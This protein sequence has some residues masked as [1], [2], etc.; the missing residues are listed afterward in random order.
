MKGCEE[1]L[2][3]L[4]C[5]APRGLLFPHAPSPNDVL[6]FPK[7]IS[8]T[9]TAVLAGKSLTTAS[10]CL[11]KD[12]SVFQTRLLLLD[13]QATT[14]FG[15]TAVLQK[16]AN[17]FCAPES[18]E[19]PESTPDLPGIF[20]GHNLPIAQVIGGDPIGPHV[21]SHRIHRAYILIILISWPV[22][23]SAASDLPP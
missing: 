22:F 14:R 2:T 7:Q 19:R 20:S 4:C 8:H 5:K 15:N 21:D 10:N 17:M 13:V 18:R 3:N 1:D 11:L 23:N 16:Y 6:L 9:P 12:G